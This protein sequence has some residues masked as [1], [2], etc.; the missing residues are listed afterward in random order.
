M[1][2]SL[3]RQIMVTI[4][5][6]LP[7][8]AFALVCRL[9]PPLPGLAAYFPPAPADE[10]A[11]LAAL[12]GRAGDAP[13]LQQGGMPARDAM[14]RNAAIPF[15]A[16]PVLPAPPFRFAGTSVDRARATDCLALAALAEAGGSD[17]GQR[18]V[19][20]VVLNRV[21]HPAFARTVCGVVF[22]GS[23]RATGCQFT[24]TCDGSLDRRYSDQAWDHARLRAAEALGGR[25]F[26]PVGNATH[27]HTDWVFPAWSPQLVKLARVDTHLFF[28]WDGY[29]GTAQAMRQPYR[30]GEPD[31][32]GA[33]MGDAPGDAATPGP[34]PT[35]APGAPSI[36]GGTLTMRDATGKANF[37][38]LDAA[39]GPAEALALAR[40]LCVGTSTCRVLG[41]AD[42]AQIPATFPIPPAARASLLFSFTRDPAG[43]E[44]A[45][46]DC[47]RIAGVGREACIPR[48][49]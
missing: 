45:L 29:W 1:Q 36:S 38:T 5:A 34:Q 9:F 20:Q 3:S 26:T 40:R 24:F 11:S 32:M 7:M 8:L 25:V 14:A 31:L 19:I 22:E 4:L 16:G 46:Y 37:V 28:R 49:R 27:Y 30:G 44:I 48:A 13:L 33:A 2:P 42:R 41:W 17:Q 47:Q 21:R 39:S 6:V 12:P 43:A 10:A 15:F 35:V 18:A 23:Q